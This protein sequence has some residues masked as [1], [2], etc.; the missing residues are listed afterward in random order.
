[1]TNIDKKS[2]DAQ[3]EMRTLPDH[4]YDGI[5]EED[6]SLPKWWVG[7]FVLVILF[8]LIYLPVVHTLDLLPQG[9][10]RRAQAIAA[11]NQEQ[12]ELA[13][14][15]SGALDKD[16]VAAGQK[17]FKVFCVSCHGSY[18]EGGLCPNLTDAYWIHSPYVDSIRSVI[19]SGV[20]S[21]GMPTWGPILGER[22]IKSIVAFVGTLWKTPPP[23][24]GKKAEGVVYDMATI[25]ALEGPKQ[26]ATA[27][28]IGKKG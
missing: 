28:S 15:A 19:T 14:E 5:R 22:K 1:M 2:G 24:A 16:P 8:S 27:D 10:L 23:V 26:S 13:L 21:K 9:E 7:L 17:Y 25:R 20:P 6:N 18:A 3:H 12:R 4:D 11:R